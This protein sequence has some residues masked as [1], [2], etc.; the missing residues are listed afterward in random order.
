M[1]ISLKAKKPQYIFEDNNGEA[2]TQTIIMFSSGEHTSV[3]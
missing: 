2:H 1:L 3:T